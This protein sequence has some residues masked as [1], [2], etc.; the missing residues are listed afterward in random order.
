MNLNSFNLFKVNEDEVKENMI[1]DIK[2]NFENQTNLIDSAKEPLQE[3]MIP[4]FK[5][6]GNR[7][8]KIVEHLLLKKLTRFVEN[9]DSLLER[10]YVLK[11]RVANKLIDFGYKH[12]SRFGRWCPVK[13]MEKQP[14]TPYYGDEKKPFTV[15]HRSYVYFLSSKEAKKKFCENPIRYLKQASPLPMVPFRL[16]V[17]GPPKAGKTS[18]ANRF[19]KE[20]GCVRLSVG[21]AV[22]AIL[23]KQPN[24]ALAQEIRQFL[25]KGKTVPDELAIQCI[26]ISILDVR[27]QLR[28]DYFLIDFDIDIRNG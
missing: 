15:L 2:N 7:R 23:D 1:T 13:L 9:R 20:F 18:L 5:I 27:C 11:T 10:T 16:S 14:I 12:L 21:E 22:R 4:R 19:T 6:D 3:A 28:G 17:I 25:F 26:E 24:T 8:Q